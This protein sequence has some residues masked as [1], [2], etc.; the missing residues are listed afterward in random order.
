M[1]EI[2]TDLAYGILF[3]G[4]IVGTISGAVMLM[5]AINMTKDSIRIALFVP[6]F[7]FFCY[8]FGGLTRSILNKKS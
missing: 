2:V 8:H 5:E 3:V 1:K 7:L 6:L 4:I